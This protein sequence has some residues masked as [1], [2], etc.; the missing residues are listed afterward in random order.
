MFQTNKGFYSKGFFILN[1]VN[2][3]FRINNTSPV[4][5]SGLGVVFI[6]FFVWLI[7]VLFNSMII[8]MSLYNDIF[9]STIIK[10]VTIK[11][12][13]MTLENKLKIVFPQSVKDM[14]TGLILSDACLS[15][16]NTKEA[17]LMI[18]QKDQDFVDH[19]YSV[20]KPLGIV[21][22]EVRH[23][24]ELHKATGK[25][26]TSYRFATFTLPYFT[27]LYSKWYVKDN[28]KTNKI[29]SSTI[30]EDL[31]PQAIGYWLAGDGHYNKS[32]GCIIICTDSFTVK[33]VDL[34]REVLLN[35]YSIESTRVL[36][37]NRTKDQYR[38]RISKREVEKVRKL[39]LNYMHLS[40]NK[41][42]GLNF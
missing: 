31:T 27:E 10:E 37:G 21:G 17:R 16:P 12:K 8:D 38:I 41:R 14:I 29:I 1:P 20:L 19:I 11:K 34:L 24:V 13:R 35:K 15:F 6:M 33:E 25:Y 5:E 32:Q 4:T 26:N 23:V 42:I 36:S 22:A 39:V 2:G 7:L 30:F 28:G 9:L 18:S 3:K 40:M